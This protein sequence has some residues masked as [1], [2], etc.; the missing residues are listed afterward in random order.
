L[1]VIFKT[2]HPSIS[3]IRYTQI[4]ASINVSAKVMDLILLLLLLFFSSQII[5]CKQQDD[6]EVDYWRPSFQ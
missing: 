6:V 1:I 4:N 3:Q 5:A 2:G